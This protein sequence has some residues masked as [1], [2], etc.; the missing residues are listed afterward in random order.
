MNWRAKLARIAARLSTPI[1]YASTLEREGERA[2][3]GP[4]ASV[5]AIQTVWATPVHASL[6]RSV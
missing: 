6:R 2:R 4:T 3:V 5:V 1:E